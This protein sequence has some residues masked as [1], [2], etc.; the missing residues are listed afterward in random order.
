MRGT[1]GV[2]SEGTVGGCSGQPCKTHLTG[3]FMYFV[4]PTPFFMEGKITYNVLCYTAHK[5]PHGLL[6]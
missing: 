5:N 4:H 1:A 3:L 2:A 6:C